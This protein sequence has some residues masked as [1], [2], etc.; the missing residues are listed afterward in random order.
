MKPPM[1][2]A[3]PD[4]ARNPGRDVCMHCLHIWSSLCAVWHENS[5]TVILLLYFTLYKTTFRGALPCLEGVPPAIG[6]KDAE[7]AR[8]SCMLGATNETLAERFGVSSRTVDNWIATIPA[9][10]DTVKQGRRVADE[11]VVVAL[12]ARATGMERKMTKVFCHD[13]QPP[14][15]HYMVQLPPDVRA[16]MFWLCNRLGCASLRRT[17]QGRRL[18]VLAAKSKPMSRARAWVSEL[19]DPVASAGRRTVER[20]DAGARGTGHGPG[21]AAR[22]SAQAAGGRAPVACDEP[23]AWPAV[24]G[25]SAA[26]SRV[27]SLRCWTHGRRSTRRWVRGAQP[28]ASSAALIQRASTG[29]CAAATTVAPP[30]PY[31]SFLELPSCRE[32]DAVNALQRIARATS[33]PAAPLVLSL[34]EQ[35]LKHLDGHLSRLHQELRRCDGIEAVWLGKGR[36]TVVR[37][38]AALPLLQWAANA[39]S[40]APPPKTIV[41][42]MLFAACHLWDYFR[43]HAHAVLAR[44]FP[45]DGERLMH[46]VLAW[47]RARGAAQINREDVR[48]DA[49]G[50]ALNAHLSLQVIQSLERAGFLCKAVREPVPAV[51]RCGGTSTRP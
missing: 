10:R 41:G 34:D 27:R 49:L 47:I 51:R 3:G 20:Q 48:R 32:S 45:S 44:V 11:S 15:A 37:L 21:P 35:A 28:S 23:T 12:F 46:R 4:E 40:V 33:E 16:C 13:G 25:C 36:S 7:I 6:P 24:L 50:Q 22:G 43:S 18:P 8:V 5:S 19:P 14:T 31:R 17:A 1:G 38:T 2:N 26:V 39:S 42:E 9:F 29:R 30:A